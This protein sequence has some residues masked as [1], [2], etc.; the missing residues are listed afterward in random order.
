MRLGEPNY[1]RGFVVRA[2]FN[3]EQTS[4][5]SPKKRNTS[6]VVG[7]SNI[8]IDAGSLANDRRTHDTEILQWHSLTQMN[9]YLLT[10]AND[11][12]LR[13]RFLMIESQETGW[14]GEA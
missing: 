14:I 8:R 7:T 5:Y 9:G 10:Y 2:T 3:V 1:I 4:C 13:R 6:I 12:F 11:R